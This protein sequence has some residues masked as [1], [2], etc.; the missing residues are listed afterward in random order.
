MGRITCCVSKTHV[1][2]FRIAALYFRKDANTN[3]KQ[4]TF[5]RRQL[6]AAEC[7]IAVMKFSLTMPERKLTIKEFILTVTEFQLTQMELHLAAPVR[8]LTITK[9]ILT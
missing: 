1:V 4:L 2:I 8:T 6:T 7:L 5:S 9:F 3:I